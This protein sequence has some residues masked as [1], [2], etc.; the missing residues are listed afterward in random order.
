[1]LTKYAEIKALT[2][3]LEMMVHYRPLRT[4]MASRLMMVHYR[5][6]RMEEWSLNLLVMKSWVMSS[7]LEDNG[8]PMALLRTAF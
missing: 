5:P 6:L 3:R 7:L 4:E 1:L 2:S 8:C